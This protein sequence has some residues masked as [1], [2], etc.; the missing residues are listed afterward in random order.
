MKKP[1][2]KRV[3]FWA[4]IVVLAFGVLGSGSDSGKN[5]GEKI[6]TE[7][8]EQKEETKSKTEYYKVGDVVKVGAVTYTLKSVTT[9]SE[10]NEFEDSK[11]NYVIKIVYH[12]KNNSDDDLPI[13]IDDDVYGPDNNKL[14]TYPISNATLDAIAPGKEKD[15]IAG[16]GTNK[17][18][19]F[20]IH[21]KPA[22]SLEKE[23]IYKAY[24]K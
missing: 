21:F 17:L 11:P 13:G 16:Y 6:G 20:E 15:V 19:N 14:D 12:V 4:I 7:K 5:G 22:L 8:T 18:G 23:A 1:I 9:T 10:R 24:V 3:W 2:Y